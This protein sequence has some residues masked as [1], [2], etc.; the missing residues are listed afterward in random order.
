MLALIIG[1]V[2]G[3]GM[4]VYLP[5]N[6]ERLIRDFYATEV[7][8]SVSPH[9]LRTSLD[10][11]ENKYVLV[12][13][14]SAEEYA[15]A[16]IPTAINIPAYKDKNTSAY[17]ETDRIMNSFR[18]LPEDKQIVTYCYSIPCMTSRKVGNILAEKGIYVKHLNIGWN[19]WRYYW[20]LWNHEHEWASALP[21]DYVVIGKEPGVW[22]RSGLLSPCTTGELGC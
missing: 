19:E 2:A 11:G 17:D 20:K 4:S 10:R 21:E 5:K 3:Y 7:A 22:P 12:D 18:E 6:E 1:G 8:V 9:S 16:H 14:R 15:A 13:L